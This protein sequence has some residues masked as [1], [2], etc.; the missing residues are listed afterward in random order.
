MDSDT[1][2]KK[3]LPSESL[4]KK[5]ADSPEKATS[6]VFSETNLSGAVGNSDK[7][8]FIG[9][10]SEQPTSGLS[11]SNMFS[12]KPTAISPL[13]NT[14]APIQASKPPSNKPKKGAAPKAPLAEPINKSPSTGQKTQPTAQ[15]Q[16]VPESP[17]VTY[18]KQLQTNLGGKFRTLYG[19]AFRSTLFSGVTKGKVGMAINNAYPNMLLGNMS[20]FKRGQSVQD[21]ILAEG[22]NNPMYEQAMNDEAGVFASNLEKDELFALTDY[23]GSSYEDYNSFTRTGNKQHDPDIEQ[24]VDLL[25]SGLNKYKLKSALTLYR[26][27]S[28]SGLSKMFAQTDAELSGAILASSNAPDSLA[29]IASLL[30]SKKG[31]ILQDAAFMSCSI[32]PGNWSGAVRLIINAPAGTKGAPVMGM[33]ANAQEKEY[34]LDKGQKFKI[35]SAEVLEKEVGVHVTVITG[36]GEGEERQ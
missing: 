5:E 32:S 28:A 3:K 34:L 4:F 22:N 30:N 19:D 9:V 10:K 13:S 18:R 20:V 1:L 21:S 7:M 12:N 2:E 15:T 14:A 36:S 23:T 16:Q 31:S 35:E 26:N 6:S 29:N 25:S 24:K 11:S 33:S 8:S 27:I 17:E